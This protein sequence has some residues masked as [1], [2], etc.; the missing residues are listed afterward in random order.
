MA[1]KLKK[2]DFALLGLAVI[3]LAF[4][5]QAPP[6]STSRV[7]YDDTH[8]R[9]YD[10]VRADGKKAAEKYCEECHNENGVPFPDGHPPKARCLFC[11]KMEKD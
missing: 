5:L 4:L 7:P 2:R 8:Q 1:I 10:I 9:F 11:H 3:I 6:E